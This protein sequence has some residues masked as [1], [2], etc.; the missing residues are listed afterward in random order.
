MNI[1][2]YVY[3]QTALKKDRRQIFL[4]R[5]LELGSYLLILTSIHFLANLTSFLVVFL[6]V[7]PA[8]LVAQPT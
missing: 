8:T 4:D 5:L 2:E 6:Q 3:T 1:Y 7:E